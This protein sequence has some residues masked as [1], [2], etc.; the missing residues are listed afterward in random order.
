MCGRQATTNK[1]RILHVGWWHQLVL[2]YIQDIMKAR[3]FDT[4]SSATREDIEV[5]MKA[6]TAPWDRDRASIRY[7]SPED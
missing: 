6:N 2:P 7:S 4:D 5:E 1:S 3:G